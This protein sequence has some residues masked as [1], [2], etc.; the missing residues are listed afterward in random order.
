MKIKAIVFGLLV[1]SAQLFAAPNIK[2]QAKVLKD[3][4][5]SAKAV[6]DRNVKLLEKTS[7]YDV[8]KIKLSEGSEYAYCCMKDYEAVD[9]LIELVEKYGKPKYVI[10][11]NKELDKHVAK[12]TKLYGH[13]MGLNENWVILN[14]YDPS[15]KTF[16]F[17]QW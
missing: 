6:V 3:A 12:V 7:D 11:E 8:F 17:F 16:Q 9:V 13:S 5:I 2:G 4:P 14:M 10:A 1:L 15:T